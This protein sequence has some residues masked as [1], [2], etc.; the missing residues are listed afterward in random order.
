MKLNLL[1]EEYGYGIIM[2]IPPDEFMKKIKKFDISNNDIYTDIF[3]NIKGREDDPHITVKYGI[4]E[5]SAEK[6]GKLVKN[7]GSIKIK[8]TS[9]SCFKNDDYDVLKIDIVSEKLHKLHHL[10]KE[11]IDNVETFPTYKPHITIAYVKKNSVND[12][13]GFTYNYSFTVDEI[14]FVDKSGH[15][16]KLS[17]K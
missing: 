1:F 16:V 17:L 8:A 10:L 11:N 3:A 6:I 14:I 15:K 7:F 13:I 2:I 5:R 4:K 12:L 9:T